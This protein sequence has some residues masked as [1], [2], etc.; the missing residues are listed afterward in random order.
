MNDYYAALTEHRT[1][2]RF[3]EQRALRMSG[4]TARPSRLMRFFR[5]Q[6]NALA[7]EVVVTTPTRTTVSRAA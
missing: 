6:V 5:P 2:I 7:T 4:F 3:A 1:R